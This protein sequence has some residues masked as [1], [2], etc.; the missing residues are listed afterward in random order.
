MD[1]SQEDFLTDLQLLQE[2][3]VINGPEAN[4]RSKVDSLIRAV[5]NLEE[6]K[7]RIDYEL[8]KQKKALTR[9]RLEL[10]NNSRGV[11]AR[12]ATVSETADLFDTRSLWAPDLSKVD[13]YL[14]RESARI[15]DD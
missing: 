11:K 6:K 2:N 8:R 4:L 13:N 5:K 15:L 3:R 1:D 10:K 9:K 7:S 14:L 12:V